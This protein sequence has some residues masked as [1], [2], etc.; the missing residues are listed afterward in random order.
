MHEFYEQN[1]DFIIA[2]IVVTIICLTGAWLVYD[3]G[4][5]E[6]I[7]HDTDGTVVEIE[8]RI[9]SIEQRVN[10]ISSRLEQTQKTID[11]I[12]ERVGR[13]RENAEIVAGGIEQAEGRLDSAIQR[14]GRIQNLIE[15]IER[16]NRPGTEN[17]PKTDMAK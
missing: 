13:S 7:Y 2:F 15:E 5:N 11:G 10:A 9:Q 6:P 12:A 16:A 14:S 3:H 17:T 1:R 4:R 8:N